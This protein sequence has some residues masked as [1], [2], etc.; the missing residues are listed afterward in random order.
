MWP[1]GSPLLKVNGRF[2]FPYIKFKWPPNSPLLKERN[3]QMVF[4]SPRSNV[5]Y[6]LETAWWPPGGFDPKLQRTT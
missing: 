2:F 3:F 6:H 4:H 1:L 5:F